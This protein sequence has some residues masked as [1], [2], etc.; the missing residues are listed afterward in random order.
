MDTIWDRNPSNSEVI[1]RC[2]G[3]EQTEWPSRTTQDGQKSNAKN[4]TKSL[5]RELHALAGLQIA[6][7]HKAHLV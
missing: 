4:K 3:D 7:L 2:G 5:S 6:Y 1:G